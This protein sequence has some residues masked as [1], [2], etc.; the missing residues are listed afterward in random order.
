MGSDRSTGEARKLVL[1]AATQLKKAEMDR[2]QL[3]WRSLGLAAAGATGIKLGTRTVLAQDIR[4]DE[5]VSVSTEA[6]QTWLRNFNPL[7]NE[8]SVRWPTHCG[9]YEPLL[10]YN[11]IN[12][13]TLPWLATKWEFSAD[14]KTLTFTIREGVKWSDGTPLTAKDVAFTFNLMKEK[15]ALTGGAGGAR[16]VLDGY[17]T[18]IEAPDDTTAVFTFSEAFTPGLWDI[19]ES[20]IVPEHIWKDVEDPVTFTNENPVG[21]RP[22]H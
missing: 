3:L 22:L 7:L 18:K 15:T 2:R 13:E 12:G 10:V 21:I 1:D 8:G 14:A 6:Q 17:V 11:V 4:Q 9:V 5:L 16:A 19:G 20:M